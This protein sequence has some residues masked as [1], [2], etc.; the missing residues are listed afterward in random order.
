MNPIPIEELRAIVASMLPQRPRIGTIL[1]LGSG[2]ASAIV[3]ILETGQRVDVSIPR[4]AQ[5][6]ATVGDTIYL[7]YFGNNVVGFP[8]GQD[9]AK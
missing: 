5:G 9:Q 7:M 6:T 8:S 2:G 1:S 4:G 3:R